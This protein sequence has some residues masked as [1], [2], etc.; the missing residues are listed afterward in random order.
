[1][2]LSF[3]AVYMKQIFS[4]FLQFVYR[5]EEAV[6]YSFVLLH[7]LSMC[8]GEKKHFFLNVMFMREFAKE[9]I[10]TKRF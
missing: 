4:F 8:L 1:M 10:I 5:Q 3:Y 2:P 7:F 6:Y 9:V